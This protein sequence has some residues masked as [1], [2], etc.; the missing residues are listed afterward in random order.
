ML[1]T[2]RR[3]YKA[4]AIKKDRIKRKAFSFAIRMPSFTFFPKKGLYFPSEG[5][6]PLRVG[7]CNTV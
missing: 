7:V 5:L 4:D 3:C 1:Q 2:A 6:N